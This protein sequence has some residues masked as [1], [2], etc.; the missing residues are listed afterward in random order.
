MCSREL[1]S[2]SAR[3]EQAAV[4]RGPMMLDNAAISSG[5]TKPGA[6]V[7]G[8]RELAE[9]QFAIFSSRLNRGI[10][11]QRIRQA[12]KENTL[13]RQLRRKM[14]RRSTTRIGERVSRLF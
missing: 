5:K 2:H 10:S 11:F 6:A 4:D 9:K 13:W 14:E 1:D 8:P 7:C 12:I 3:R